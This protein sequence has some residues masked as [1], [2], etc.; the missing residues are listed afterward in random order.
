MTAFLSGRPLRPARLGAFLE[1]FSAKHLR[2]SFPSIES[3]F[4]CVEQL[5][6]CRSV[7][8]PWEIGCNGINDERVQRYPFSST[9]LVR[10]FIRLDRW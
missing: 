3:A 10:C 8:G 1:S 4:A 6:A 2:C 7:M 5:I 9:F